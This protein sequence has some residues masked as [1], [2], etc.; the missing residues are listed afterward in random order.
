MTRLLYPGMALTNI[1]NNRKTYIPYML[2]C[3]LTISIF[4]IIGSLSS[5]ESIRALRGGDIIQ[6]YMTFGQ[7]AVAVFSVIFL[8]YINSFLVRKRITEFGLYNIL[9]MEK[10][11][12]S[13]IVFFETL[14]TFFIS[15]AVGLGVGILLDKL[16]YLIVLNILDAD[17]TFGFHISAAALLRSFALFGAIFFLILLST[18]RRIYQ[19]DPIHLLRSDSFGEREPK[20]KWILAVLGIACLAAGYIIAVTTKNPIA[21]FTMFFA[22][23]ILVIIGTYLVFTAGSITL[24]KLLKRKKSYYYNAK[25]FISISGMMYRMKRNA[26]SLGNICILS[27]MVIVMLSTTLAMY[28]GASDSVMQ[29]YPKEIMIESPA[30]DPQ[31]KNTIDTLQDTMTDHGLQLTD[32][33]YYRELSISTVYDKGSDQFSTD[34]SLYDG[35][36]VLS[37][38]NHLSSLVFVPLE[39]YNKAMRQQEKLAEDE[40][41]IYSNRLPL[42]TDSVNVLG[43]SFHV[44]GTLDEFMP[45]GNAAANILSSHFIV[46]KDLSVV[47]A[48]DKLQKEAYGKYASQIMTHYMADVSGDPEEN[49]DAI[50][51]ACSDTRKLVYSD[52]DESSDLSPAFSGSIQCRSGE[53][54]SYLTDFSGLFFIGIFLGLLF[55]IATVLIMY[56]KQISEG[57]ED[58]ERFAILQNVGMSHR[59]VRRTINSQVLT[60]FF[61][62]LVTAGIHT[63][64]A[65]PFLYRILTLLS[66]FNIKL[67]ACCCIGCFLTFAVF[68]GIVYAATSKLYYKIVKK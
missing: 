8:F 54:E 52:P 60:V 3:I 38:Y 30:D 11:H 41:L 49:E 18:L 51:A 63:A 15:I 4:Y 56:Y 40:V 61:L 31:F 22:A 20:A 14:Y 33:L 47:E 53:V 64:F 55:I 24:L 32:P 59:E 25:H 19:T 36:D 13:R 62:P 17:I 50:L 21:A 2:S 23:V 42:D 68:Y 27:T 48:L 6:S 10:R 5:N 66:L 43:R 44:A 26:V 58:K 65:F 34:L 57:Y 37:A 46:V 9:G 67:F 39:D 29:R 35:T 12:I 16:M 45:S 1:K 28:L 7:A